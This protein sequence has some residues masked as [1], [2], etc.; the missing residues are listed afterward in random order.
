MDDMFELSNL[1]DMANATLRWHKNMADRL[2]HFASI[3]TGTEVDID[4]VK[5]IMEGDLLLGFITGM[6][7]AYQELMVNPPFVVDSDD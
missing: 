3:P 2:Q 7:A 5:R 1:E 6:R 4:S